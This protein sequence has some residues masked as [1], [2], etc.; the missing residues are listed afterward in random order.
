MA[1]KNLY[2]YVSP[3]GEI[4]MLHASSEERADKVLA[5]LVKHPLCWEL[6]AYSGF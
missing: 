3:T 6:M 2:Q 5:G 1:R 4:V